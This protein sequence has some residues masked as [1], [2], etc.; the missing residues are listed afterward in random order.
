MKTTY[1]KGDDVWIHLGTAPGKLSKGKVLEV[2]DLSEH[3]YTF[4]NYLIEIPTSIEP[5]L[6]VRNAMTMSEDAKGPVGL[7][8]KLKESMKNED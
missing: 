4:L 8:R 3:G 7:F 5:L 6:E 1:A 2:F